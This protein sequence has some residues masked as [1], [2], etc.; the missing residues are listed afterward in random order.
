MD[1]KAFTHYQRRITKVVWAGNAYTVLCPVILWYFSVSAIGWIIYF[2]TLLLHYSL[3]AMSDAIFDSMSERTNI[4]SSWLDVRLRALEK[5]LH[6]QSGQDSWRESGVPTND[7]AYYF[8]NY[9]EKL[10]G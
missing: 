9:P 10:E 5:A 1:K 7:P 8:S 6:V 2:S 4:Q 3:A